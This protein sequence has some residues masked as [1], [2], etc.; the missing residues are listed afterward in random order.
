[1]SN[2]FRKPAKE[3]TINDEKVMISPLKVGTLLKIQGLTQ[4]I[5][6]AFAK[7]RSIIAN[8]YEQVKNST[9][10]PV[11]G[12]K[13]AIEYVEKTT[14]KAPELSAISLLVKNK[15]E[16]LK[17]LFDCLFQMDLLDDIFRSSVDRFRD[18]PKG[19]LF[20]PM[21]EQALDIPTALEFLLAIVDVNAGG[22]TE[23]GK[24]S[25]LLTMFQGAAK[26]AE[27]NAV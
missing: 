12:D 8:D 20:D 3:F 2:I 11:E 23:L 13:D 22:F 19:A 27:T 10:H 21:S 4:H 24:F 9:P 6:E 16:G 15:Q 18:V 1:M 17:A 26:Q 25:R 7:L 5:A 14:H